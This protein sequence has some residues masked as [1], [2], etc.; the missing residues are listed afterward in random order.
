[1]GQHDALCVKQSGEDCRVIRIKLNQFVYENAVLSYSLPHIMAEKHT[2][3]IGYDEIT[4]LTPYI[5]RTLKKLTES[6]LSL[7][8]GTIGGKSSAVAEMGDRGHNG[9]G[10]KRGGAAVPLSRELGP[11]LIQCGACAEI[12]FGTKWR[13]HPSSH[14]LTIDMSQKL[15]WGGCAFFSGGSWVP[16]EYKVAWAE[17]YRHTKWHLS[18]SSHL[19]TVDTGRKLGAVPL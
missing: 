15:G 9:H 3:K 18:P 2:T 4:L 7:P 11:S 8:Y 19:A 5:Q 1:M 12:Y 10:P 14:L 16:I 17:A 6:Q 13:L